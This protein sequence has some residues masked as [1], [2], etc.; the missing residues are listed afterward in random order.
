MLNRRFFLEAAAI[1]IGAIVCAAVSNGL[2]AR[3][4]KLK[5]VA[6]SVQTSRVERPSA[7]VAPGQTS[8]VTPATTTTAPVPLA[9]TTTL[10][11]TTTAVQ[12]PL[13][14]TVAPLL[15]ST[16]APAIAKPSA[17]A[18]PAA[19]QPVPDV[20]AKQFPAHPDKAYTEITS[21]DAKTLFD[22]GALFFDARRTSVFEE[23]HIR[24]AK[25]ISVWEA[26]LDEKVNRVFEQNLD[27]ESPIVVYCAGGNC[28]DSHMLSQRLWGIGLNAVF[29]YKD[30]YP[31]W[32]A[33][34]WP[35]ATGAQQ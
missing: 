33:K 30:G 2:A 10:G 5:W 12:A 25:N 34:G 16:A 8:V 13:T 19:T 14:A 18:T 1:V 26:D 6:P 20:S 9:T 35:I 11:T 17:A 28:E 29:V 21:E 27:P 4:R 23:G 24:G 15:T 3:E 32:K 31:D 22:R 7:I